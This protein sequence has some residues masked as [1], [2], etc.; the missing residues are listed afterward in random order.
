MKGNLVCFDQCAWIE[1]SETY[2]GHINTPKHRRLLLDIIDLA[3]SRKALFPV[4]FERYFETIK[5]LDTGRRLKLAEF[6]TRLSGCLCLGPN[7]DRLLRKE[8]YNLTLDRLNLP[9]QKHVFPDTILGI[10]LKGI[11]HISYKWIREDGSVIVPSKEENEKMRNLEEYLDSPVFFIKALSDTIDDSISLRD[12]VKET[13]DEYRYFVKQ[14]V[15]NLDKDY[16]MIKEKGIDWL[17]YKRIKQNRFFCETIFPQLNRILRELDIKYEQ[18]VP[19]PSPAKD[20]DEF[21]SDLPS[22]HTMLTLLD[23]RDRIRKRMDD[24]NDINDVSF[25]SYCIP[26]GS[27]VVT[28]QKW[29]DIC[30]YKK[31]DRKFETTIMSV[32]EMVDRSIE[33]PKV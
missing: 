21:Y 27:V 9:N 3:K 11:F 33:P 12:A 2:H 31:L 23:E 19:H 22:V 14:Y 4:T 6:M 24:P 25:L 8:C 13:Q 5:P 32:S 10:G 20:W 26:Y 28:D 1:L 18:L 16:E 30:R 15:D 29:A 7:D 17:E